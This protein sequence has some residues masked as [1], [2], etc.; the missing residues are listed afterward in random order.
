MRLSRIGLRSS[1]LTVVRDAGDAS[2]GGSAADNV[3]VL[4]ALISAGAD[5]AARLSYLTL[6]DPP[7]VRVALAAG[8]GAEISVRVGHSFSKGDGTS[9]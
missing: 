5:R 3:A 4:S 8:Q 2:T 9:L 1:G 6:C 7:A